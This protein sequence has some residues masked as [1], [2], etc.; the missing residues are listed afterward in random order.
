MGEDLFSKRVDAQISTS[1]ENLISAVFWGLTEE[2]VIEFVIELDR[3]GE[4]YHFTETLHKYFKAQ[5]KL[6]KKRFDA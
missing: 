5:H 6:L 3:F 4:S 1:V 2:E